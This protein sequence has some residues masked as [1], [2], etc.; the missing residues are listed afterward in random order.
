M[1]FFG[2]SAHAASYIYKIQVT[3]ETV[4][5]YKKNIGPFLEKRKKQTG[6]L[7]TGIGGF[8]ASMSGVDVKQAR[9]FLARAFEDQQMLDK[10]I[11]GLDKDKVAIAY[12]Q[13][14]IDELPP[15][16]IHRK[17]TKKLPE[18]MKKHKH[19][20]FKGTETP[21]SKQDVSDKDFYNGAACS[22]MVYHLVESDGPARIKIPQEK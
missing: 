6:L 15:S 20:K 4:A 22:F 8:F 19:P 13:T 3:P 1:L 2:F 14:V 5:I 17:N 16:A 21:W 9:A 11:D 10:A 18:I 7:N 12:M